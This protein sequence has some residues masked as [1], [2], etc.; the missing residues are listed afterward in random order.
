MKK[1]L[2]YLFS[3]LCV[4]A[5]DCP[6]GEEVCRTCRKPIEECTCGSDYFS[7]STLV[8]GWQMS[9]GYDKAYMSYCGIIP[10]YIVFSNVK[11]KTYG[12]KKCTMTYSISNEPQWY[13]EDMYYSYVRKTLTFY[14]VLDSSGRLEK[15]IEFG[16]E[17]YLFPCLYLMDAGSRRYNTT[18]EWKKVRVTTDY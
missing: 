5:C 10:K 12:F 8:G 2:F 17:S 4:I 9:G 13:E 1:V 11:E 15:F 6:F 18:Y 7:S 14:R 3:L 16:Y